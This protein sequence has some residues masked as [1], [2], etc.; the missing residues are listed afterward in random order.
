MKGVTQLLLTSVG[1]CDSRVK[2]DS[3][4]SGLN[5]SW[6]DVVS[7]KRKKKTDV[8]MTTGL[9]GEPSGKLEKLTLFTKSKLVKQ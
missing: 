3:D 8:V 2:F 1:D 4:E 7:R 9:G 6:I 5:T